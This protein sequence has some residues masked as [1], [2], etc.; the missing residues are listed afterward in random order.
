[1]NVTEQ[2]VILKDQMANVDF[3]MKCTTT[4]HSPKTCMRCF[5][6]YSSLTWGYFDKPLKNPILQFCGFWPSLSVHTHT[7]PQLLPAACQ[8]EMMYRTARLAASPV[9]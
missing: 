1:M 8:A 9:D 6:S 2:Q 5:G 7:R 4:F 3:R